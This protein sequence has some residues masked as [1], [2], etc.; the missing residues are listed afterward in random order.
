M[1]SP[2][3]VKGGS[4]ACGAD[5]D[6]RGVGDVEGADAGKRT[7]D[8]RATLA[9]RVVARDFDHHPTGRGVHRAAGPTRKPAP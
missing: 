8:R 4:A 1:G 9:L 7:G 5:Q 2:G 6:G 3:C